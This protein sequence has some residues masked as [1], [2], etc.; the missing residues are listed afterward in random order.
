MMSKEKYMIDNQDVIALPVKVGQVIYM[1]H[2]PWLKEIIIEPYQVTS[3]SI[4]CN[5]KGVWTKK[6]RANWIYNGRVT[7]DSHDPAFDDIDKTVF[8]S[9]EAAEAVLLGKRF[10]D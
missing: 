9:R 3:I 8:F 6:F 5:K 4:T 1:R 2:Q 7:T 10:T